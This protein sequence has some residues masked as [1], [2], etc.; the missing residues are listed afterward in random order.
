MLQNNNCFNNPVI[1]KIAIQISFQLNRRDLA[2]GFLTREYL[3][4]F[5]EIGAEEKTFLA[6]LLFNLGLEKESSLD[7]LRMLLL[8]AEMMDVVATSVA[9]H[10]V[11]ISAGL[12]GMEE[13]MFEG[14]DEVLDAIRN[15]E[16]MSTSRRSRSAILIYQIRY[17][18]LSGVFSAFNLRAAVDELAS[19]EKFSVLNA[20]AVM[21]AK[22][23]VEIA[24]QLTVQA[25]MLCLPQSSEPSTIGV[26]VLEVT[27]KKPFLW[28]NIFSIYTEIKQRLEGKE[29]IGLQIV[30]NAWIKLTSLSGDNKALKEGW[31]RCVV[32]LHNQLTHEFDHIQANIHQPSQALYAKIRRSLD[33]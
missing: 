12:K 23:N 5:P 10:L 15:V 6:Q 14:R 7:K 17:S 31:G 19:M 25:L 32:G 3:E 24:D 11:A 18:V 16:K 30:W 28:P 22:K 21:L 20:L 4:K 13:G 29:R 33:Q 1:C 2:D 27:A 26:A 8:A 9:V